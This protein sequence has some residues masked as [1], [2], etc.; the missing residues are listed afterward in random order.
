[1]SGDGQAILFGQDLKFQPGEFYTLQSATFVPE[2]PAWATVVGQ[3]YRLTASSNAPDFG[4]TLLSITYQGDEVPPGEEGWL[5]MFYYDGSA[6]QPLTTTLN[7]AFNYASAPTQRKG[8]YA[9]MSSLEIPLYG[10]GWDAFGYPVQ[11]T[12]PVTDALRSIKG[13]YATV[14]RY[15]AGKA[16]YNRWDMYD[17]GVPGWV[18][19]LHELEFGESYL[20]S[21][22]QAITLYLKGASDT[23]LAGAN[24]LLNPP[25]TYYGQVIA[26]P[27]LVPSVGMTVTAWINDNLCGQDRTSK[28]D[29]QVVYS[30]NVFADGLGDSAGCGTPERS[31]RFEVGSQVMTPIARWDNNQVREVVLSSGFRIYLPMVLKRQ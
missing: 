11:G 1:M 5:K 28:V 15:D 30:I 16:F 24:S 9:L 22:T 20:I 27:S 26:G 14:Y 7:V 2:P 12:R 21:L 25:S 3:A 13:Y 4:G 31:V 19:D 10:P 18:N 17:V 29:D 8:L 23:T 6:W